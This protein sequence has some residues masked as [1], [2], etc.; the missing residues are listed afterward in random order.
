MKRV[1]S[2]NRGTNQSGLENTNSI[3][4]AE[5]NVDHH[6]QIEEYERLFQIMNGPIENLVNFSRE[7]AR[8]NSQKNRTKTMIRPLT[9]RMDGSKRAQTAVGG[10]K[11]P[12][13]PNQG[14][15]IIPENSQA[16]KHG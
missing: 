6:Q 16:G 14:L 7:Q 13:G 2:M 1:G 3:S 12:I 4:F 8:I 10:E 9:V 11:P 15:Q 5:S